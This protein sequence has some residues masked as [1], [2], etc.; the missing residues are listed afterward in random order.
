MGRAFPKHG[1]GGGSGDA[2]WELSQVRL[3][4]K[5]NEIDTNNDHSDGPDAGAIT[6]GGGQSAWASPKY[7]ARGNMIMVPKPTALTATYACKYDA[8]NRLVEVKSGETVVAKYEYDGTD[9]RI[10]AHIDTQAPAEPNGVDHYRHFYYNASWQLLETRKS[11]SENT[12][13]ET[14]GHWGRYPC[15]SLAWGGHGEFRGRAT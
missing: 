15:F 14:L 10:K 1:D 7:D 9:R 11:S 4:N 13:P 12:E 6:E 8:W 3:H 2:G 5:V